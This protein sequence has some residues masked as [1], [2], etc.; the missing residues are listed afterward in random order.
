MVSRQLL[1]IIIII[2]INLLFLRAI[3]NYNYPADLYFGCAVTGDIHC[4]NQFRAY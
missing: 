1:I 3:N 4:V 2:V